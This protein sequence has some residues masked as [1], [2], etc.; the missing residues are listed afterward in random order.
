[1]KAMVRLMLDFSYTQMGLAFSSSSSSKKKTWTVTQ[2]FGASHLPRKPLPSEPSPCWASF[3]PG[4]SLIIP[5]STAQCGEQ[6]SELRSLLSIHHGQR[7]SLS[8]SPAPKPQPQPQLQCRSQLPHHPLYSRVTQFH[9][10]FSL[11]LVFPHCR[12]GS[13]HQWLSGENTP[14][15][16]K[17]VSSIT[18]SAC[19]SGPFEILCY[20]GKKI[21][22][23]HILRITINVKGQALWNTVPVCKEMLKNCMKILSWSTYVPGT[24][25]IKGN[26]KH[27]GSLNLAI[28]F[29]AI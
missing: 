17:T 26:S 8:D 21:R 22:H 12:G 16:G 25:S 11:H 27:V 6:I 29:L 28:L 18:V 24:S 5:P 7:I 15:K 20:K 13:S 2:H 19:Q 14:P 23:R 9:L 4:N 10:G 3:L 1:M